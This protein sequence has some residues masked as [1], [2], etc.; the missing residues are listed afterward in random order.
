MSAEIFT[1][2]PVVLSLASGLASLV[3]SVAARR[4]D[5]KSRMQTRAAL[6][7]H[8]LSSA[9]ES[10]DLESLGSYLETKLGS[11]SVAEFATD[12]EVRR[13][14][15]DFVER[16]SEFTESPDREESK[17]P[18]DISRLRQEPSEG[19]LAQAERMVREGLVWNGLAVA[20]RT[21]ELRLREIALASD[22]G[23]EKRSAGRLLADLVRLELVHQ[24]APSYLQYSIDVANRGIHGEDVS[25]GEALEALAAAARG[26]SLL[27][28][29][30]TTRG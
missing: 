27:E 14:V 21:V 30:T 28:E 10:D 24:E 5:S 18:A 2:L 22:L 12:D 15:T 11:V 1:T 26:L 9:L 19:E 13:Q 20:R 25:Q 3:F 23:T 4:R 6:E 7:E 29:N 8:A 17:V 16:V